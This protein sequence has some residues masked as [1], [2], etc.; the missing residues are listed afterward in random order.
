MINY[1]GY[2]DIAINPD[3]LEWVSQAQSTD[4]EQRRTKMIPD[5]FNYSRKMDS[6]VVAR[7]ERVRAALHNCSDYYYVSDFRRRLHM[8][9]TW[10]WCDVANHV[11]DGVCTVEQVEIA[12]YIDGE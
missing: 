10:Q 8:P 7:L 9:A 5:N 1:T 3:T 4:P 6:T 2:N 12:A 11:R